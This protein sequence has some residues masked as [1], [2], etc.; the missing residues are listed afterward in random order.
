MKPFAYTIYFPCDSRYLYIPVDVSNR[1]LVRNA[2]SKSLSEHPNLESAAKCCTQ[3]RD[4]H[5]E[6]N[7]T[8]CAPILRLSKEEEQQFP[9]RAFVLDVLNKMPVQP[10]C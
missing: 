7:C 8:L 9:H 6:I 5:K 1:N 2:C 3:R 10:D 4:G